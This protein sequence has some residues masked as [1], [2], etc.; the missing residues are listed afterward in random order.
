V[1]I[2]G[3]M[4]VK[5]EDLYVQRALENIIEFCDEILVLDHM[6]KDGTWEIAQ[7]MATKYAKVRPSRISHTSESQHP[8]EKY[9]G[10]PTWIFAVDG[11][12]IY[13]PDGL[14][15]FRRTLESGQLD[16][17]WSIHG[18]V[19]NCVALD[20]SRNYATGY[21]APPARSMT[22]LNNFSHV[23][24]WT[25]CSQRL[26]D[27]K[28]IF[29]DGFKEE[30]AHYLLHKTIGWDEANFRCLHM[31]LMRRSSLQGFL[32]PHYCPTE[33][34]KNQLAS[35][36]LVTKLALRLQTLWTTMRRTSGKDQAYRRGPLVEKEISAFFSRKDT[37]KKADKA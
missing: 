35:R 15:R 37:Q 26:H 8:L 25:G 13:D 2:V 16:G 27:G 18:N 31:A 22:K 32:V 5:N 30:Q 14:L 20:M 9:C 11:D 3:I 10:T 6:S 7:N 24:S 23:R 28:L 34:I 21:L 4:M 1:N 36:R 29:Q 17:V 33:T 19:L 12:E